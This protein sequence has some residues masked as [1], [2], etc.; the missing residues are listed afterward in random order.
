MPAPS[1]VPGFL[2]RLCFCGLL[3]VAADALARPSGP[4][5]EVV[6][7]EIEVDLVGDVEG[8]DP[9][10]QR[11]LSDTIW[12][13]DWN[14]DAGFVHCDETGWTH[15][16][17]RIRNDGTIYW[18]LETGFTTATGMA[19]NSFAVGHHGS[20][21]CVGGVGYD[22]DWYQGIRIGYTDVAGAGTPTLS[23]DYIVDSEAYYDFLGIETDSLCSS[24]ARVNYEQ[25]PWRSPADFRTLE[26]AAHGLNRNGGWNALALSEY[27]PGTHCVYISF[28]SDYSCSPCDGDQPTTVGEGAI[29]DNIVLVDGSGTRSEDF[30]DASLD[31]GRA[32]NIADSAPFGTW[33]R[34]YRHV[35]D[36]DRCMENRTCSW[37]WTDHTTPTL[38][39]DPSMGFAPG[40]YVVRNW[41]D[42]VV[43]SPWVSLAS[44]SAA[45]GTVLTYRLFPGNF[46]GLSRIVLNWSVRGRRESCGRWGHAA[47]W[48]S[49]S[50]FTWR[51][52]VLDVSPLFRSRLDRHPGAFPH[53]GLAVDRRGEFPSAFDSWSGAVHRSRAHWTPCLQ[54]SSHRRRHRLP[55]AGAGCVRHRDQPRGHSS[56]P[57]FPVDGGPLRRLRLLPGDGAGHQQ[58]QPEPDHR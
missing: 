9:A 7:P 32:L 45:S 30:E 1:R 27:G 21:C 17:N 22:N 38:F 43:M 24:Y 31:L 11:A 41:L 33:A 51:S 25:A 55:F 15:V 35:T 46:F 48:N 49:L 20:A 34:L 40:G 36:N 44:S 4:R 29:V 19:G 18:H 50:L 6:E 10:P 12:I 23:L 26:S 37:L 42:D 53:V 14:F 28:F 57:A 56:R 39:N 54:R 47:Q 16:D 13:A 5:H 2:A 52:L 3:L 58:E 8:T